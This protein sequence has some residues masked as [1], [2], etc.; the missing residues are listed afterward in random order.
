MLAYRRGDADAFEHLYQRHKDGLFSFL[1]RSLPRPALAEELA[2][3]TWMAVVRAAPDYEPRAR[4]RTW[5]FQ[6]ARNRVI[7]HWRRSDNSEEPLLDEPASHDESCTPSERELL[8]AVAA[9]PQEQRDALLLRE[10]GFSVKD[11]AAITD[12]A[13]ETVK[14]RIRYGR[15]TLQDWLEAQQ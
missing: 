1:F 10:Q 3:D 4:F 9:L 6:I 15:R 2:Q 13:E 14:S 12:A 11:V 7:D 5:L 8:A